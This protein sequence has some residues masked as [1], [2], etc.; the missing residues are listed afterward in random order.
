MILFG[1]IVLVIV[2]LAAGTAAALHL[3][4]W[5]A[6]IIGGGASILAAPPVLRLFPDRFVDGRSSLVAFA[7]TSTVLAVSLI[8]MATRAGL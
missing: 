7:A 3:I 1:S 2:C 8:W 5:Y 4:P 6:A